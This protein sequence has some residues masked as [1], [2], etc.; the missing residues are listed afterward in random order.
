MTDLRSIPTEELLRR[1]YHVSRHLTDADK[2]APELLSLEDIEGRSVGLSND[3]VRRMFA[4]VRQHL[5]TEDKAV[6][7]LQRA[8]RPERRS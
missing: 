8:Y 2:E 4:A 6:E 7:A 5:L 1:A 3:E